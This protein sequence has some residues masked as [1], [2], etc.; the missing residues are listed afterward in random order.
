MKRSAKKMNNQDNF[1][2]AEE[3]ELEELGKCDSPATKLVYRLIFVSAIILIGLYIVYLLTKPGP[4]D[5]PPSKVERV[6]DSIEQIQKDIH[7][8][9]KDEDREAANSQKKED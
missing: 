9:T 2:K 7:Q 6:V 1:E 4:I 5:R 8:M 3:L